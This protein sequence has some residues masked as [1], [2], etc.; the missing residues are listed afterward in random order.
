MCLI[1][2]KMIIT[3]TCNTEKLS[4]GLFM[5]HYGH[6]NNSGYNWSSVP[7]KIIAKQAK[8]STGNEMY[9]NLQI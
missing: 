5:K 7:F 2:V 9:K 3:L 1:R 6:I 4:E 8:T